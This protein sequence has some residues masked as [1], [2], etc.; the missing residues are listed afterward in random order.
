MWTFFLFLNFYWHIVA[1][2]C[3]VSSYCTTK[4]S[5]NVYVYLLFLK[6]CSHL[7]DHR[8]LTRVP[9]IQQVLLSYLFYT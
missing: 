7:G 5:A 9:C 2:Q 8:A 1:L 3:R 6:F 4:K